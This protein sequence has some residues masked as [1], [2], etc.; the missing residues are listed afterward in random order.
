M[1]LTKFTSI[2]ILLFLLL[3]S[4]RN[5][6]PESNSISCNSDSTFW[7]L[8]KN[9][10]IWDI[11]SEK[12]LPHQD[13]IEMS[14]RKLSSIVT[15]RVD[16]AKHLTINRELIFPTYRT[17]LKKGEPEWFN[18]RAYLKR[19]YPDSLMPRIF[20]NHKL[21]HPKIIEARINGTLQFKESLG[22]SVLLEKVLFPSPDKFLFIENW[23]ITNQGI[24][25]VHLLV[26]AASDKQNEMGIYGKYELTL[27]SK[28]VNIILGKG[29]SC[30]I[31]V[32]F[33]TQI[34]GKEIYS[35][36]FEEELNNRQTFLR[37]INEN[38]VLNTPDSIL[39][40]AFSFAKIR[41][42]ESLF[43]SKMGLVHSPGGGR[44]YAGVWAN[45]QVEY[46][47]P[48]FPFLGYEPANEA[49][50][51]AYRIFAG[52][53][54]PDYSK[55]WSSHEM[56]GD[57]PCC[58]RDRGDAAM[59]AY[60]ASRFA[61]ASGKKN[62]A[63]ELWPAIEWA[64]E[65]CYRKTNAEGVITSE[66]DEMEGRIATGNANLATSSLTYGALITSSFLANELGKKDIAAQ[67]L[68]R[69]DS[70]KV[71]LENYFGADIDGF[72]TYKYFKEHDK[73]RHWI[74]LPLTVGIYNRKEGTVN[75]LM[76]K[77]WTINGLNVETGETMF[78]DRG[79]LYALRGVFMA[80]ESEK[81][82][83]KL[84]E[85]T[86][87]RFLGNHVPY[88]VEAWPEGNQAH[89]AAESALYCRIYTE[90]IF[91]ILPSGLESFDCTP[92]MPE[93]WNFMELKNIQ[94]FGKSFNLKVEH[95]GKNKLTITVFTSGKEFLKKTIRQGETIH[96]ALK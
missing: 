21:V 12:R 36:N 52:D 6:L 81:A 1:K 88:P 11:S 91:G 63:A 41:T 68:K 37:T 5:E 45:D 49:S 26:S 16:S 19:N 69:A 14:G 76:E 43:D 61:L 59:Y 13:N 75:A 60:G 66:T 23:K 72:H 4:C 33:S 65:Y 2:L 10:I 47:G 94:A 34:S 85:Y 87:R 92:S 28:E 77:L 30:N 42:S 24:D 96:V 95:T 39:N 32:Y 35:A 3:F 8:E 93:Q 31:P 62:I 44:Y 64:L 18:Y 9:E 22:N 55:I 53:M 90:G 78:W 27:I 86:C 40:A 17:L 70:L 54:K 73:I 38:L 20:V 25:S 56:E 15:Y 79:T 46:A 50:L 7:K 51:N 82:Y 84:K 67:Y 71:A 48:F 89:L 74:C 29:E 83:E 80:G 57:L 58:S